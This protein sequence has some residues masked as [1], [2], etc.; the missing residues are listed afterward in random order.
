MH[1]ARGPGAAIPG[2]SEPSTSS[3]VGGAVVSPLAS[4]LPVTS[5]A[6]S[7][8]VPATS[9]VFPAAV[10]ATS[11][12]FS[13]AVPASSLVLPRASPATSL[14][15]SAAVDAP[16]LTLAHPSFSLSSND[17]TTPSG[18]HMKESVSHC[19]WGGVTAPPGPTIA[20]MDFDWPDEL[21]ALQAEAD[22]VAAKAV[23]T[24]G[25]FDDGWINGYSREFSRELGRRGWIGMTW[26]KEDG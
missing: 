18:D 22:D 25:V 14:V 19:W 1:L 10:P 13:A 26:P 17:M 24:H 6:F 4:P 7:T 11:L 8:T 12:V 15:F 16:L 23:A 3:V 21:R 2:Y 5:L 9:L 20:A